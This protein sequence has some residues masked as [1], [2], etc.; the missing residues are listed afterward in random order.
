MV[1]RPNRLLVSETQIPPDQ[2]KM[3]EDVIRNKK[4]RHRLSDMLKK[5]DQL[6]Y[7]IM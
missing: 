3:I 1:P 2:A 6:E 5:Q 7:W 4:S